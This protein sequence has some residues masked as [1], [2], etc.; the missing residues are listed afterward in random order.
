MQM[1]KVNLPTTHYKET[2]PILQTLNLVSK[3]SQQKES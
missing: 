1:S 3:E 2:D